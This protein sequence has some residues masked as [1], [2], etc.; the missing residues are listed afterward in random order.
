[1]KYMC[2]ICGK[3]VNEN[4][5]ENEFVNMNFGIY[6]NDFDGIV[7]SKNIK[8]NSVCLD[9]AAALSISI[10]QKIKELKEGK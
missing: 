8:F 10:K 1:M 2:E 9:C 6:E 4:I 5:G 3:K 7:I